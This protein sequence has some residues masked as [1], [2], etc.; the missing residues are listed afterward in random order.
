MLEFVSG[1]VF[2]SSRSSLRQV[3]VGSVAFQSPSSASQSASRSSSSVPVG[4]RVFLAASNR[5][6][7]SRCR[8]LSSVGCVSSVRVPRIVASASGVSASSE[9]A[10]VSVASAPDK[11]AIS[12]KSVLQGAFAGSRR[13]AMRK[14]SSCIA[15]RLADPKTNSAGR[16]VLRQLRDGCV[17]WRTERSRQSAPVETSEC[18]MSSVSALKRAVSGGRPLPARRPQSVESVALEGVG[19]VASVGEWRAFGDVVMEAMRACATRRVE[20]D[21]PARAAP[22]AVH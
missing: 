12:P 16:V 10:Y 5:F 18:V 9:F 17:A 6:D 3:P 22:R 14:K 1:V 13:A 7:A 19:S 4:L 2:R 20:G 8:E 21:E 15:S 11:G